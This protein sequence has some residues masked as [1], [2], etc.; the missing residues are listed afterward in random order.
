MKRNGIIITEVLI[1]MAVFIIGVLALAASMTF[2]LKA[3]AR[4]REQLVADK[5][6]VNDV[7]TYMIGRVLSH[8]VSPSGTQVTK[9]SS[10]QQLLINGRTVGFSVY[11][12][13]RE[14]KKAS[15]YYILQRED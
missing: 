8:D 6:L 1:A 13:K 10:G 9:I 5:T 11:R 2:T 12:Y 14:G 15:S 7:N 4:S 3:V